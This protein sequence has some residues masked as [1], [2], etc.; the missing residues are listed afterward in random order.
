MVLERT[1]KIPVRS[2]RHPISPIVASQVGLQKAVPL[3]F[4]PDTCQP[5]L[6]YHP[7]LKCPEQPFHSPFSLWG[8]SMDNRHA[9]LLKAPFE[10][11]HELPVFQVGP[12]S[13]DIVPSLYRS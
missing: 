13:S 8:I 11:A 12:Q 6:F 3:V 2:R 10:L 1:M 7:I 5:H 9:E 4:I